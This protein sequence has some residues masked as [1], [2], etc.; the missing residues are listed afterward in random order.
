MDFGMKNRLS[1]IFN[2][3]TGKTV[4]LAVD[5]GYFQGPTT[6]LKDMK[7]VAPLIPNADCLFVTEGYSEILSIP[8]STPRSVSGYQGVRVSLE[9]CRTRTLPLLWKRR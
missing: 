9:S 7:G 4:M 8:K 2:P 3:K 1:K 5:H 6:G